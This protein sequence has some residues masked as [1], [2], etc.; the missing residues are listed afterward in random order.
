M[1]MMTQSQEDLGKGFPS[2][3]KSM[4]KGPGVV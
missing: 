2:S 1:E 3:K 4:C